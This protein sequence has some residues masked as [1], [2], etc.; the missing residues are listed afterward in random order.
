MAIGYPHTRQVVTQHRK[1]ENQPIK[2]PLNGGEEDGCLEQMLKDYSRP[3]ILDPALADRFCEWHAD[4]GAQDKHG[5]AKRQSAGVP[6]E[7]GGKSQI[8]RCALRFYASNVRPYCPY[9]DRNPKQREES[10]IRL[11]A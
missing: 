4:S 3:I 1:G 7:H 6:R 8:E 5:I 10:L 2:R 11:I 9:K